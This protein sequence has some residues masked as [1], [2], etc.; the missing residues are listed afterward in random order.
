MVAFLGSE[1]AT[2]GAGFTYYFFVRIGDIGAVP[3]L[4]GSLVIVN[5]VILV[6]SSFTI[7]FAHTS[8][9]KGNRGR[10]QALLGVTLLLGIVFIAGQIYEYYEFIVH[11]GF[12]LGSGDFSQVF[13]S[14]FYALTGLHGLHVT[15]GAVLIGIVFVRALRGQYSA[16]RHVSVSTVSMY[17]HFVDIVW[18]FLVVVLY[19]GAPVT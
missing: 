16:E 10:F 15:L 14:G 3:E 6:L 18:I 12:V 1:V 8:L 19:V 13:A 9:L 2:F 7:H 5:T 17:W 4:F 11:E